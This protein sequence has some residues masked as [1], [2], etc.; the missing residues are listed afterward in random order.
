MFRAG[1]FLGRV[2]KSDTGEMGCGGVRLATRPAQPASTPERIEPMKTRHSAGRRDAPERIMREALI[3]ELDAIVEQQDGTR[4]ANKQLV[5]R[6][7]IEKACKADTAAIKEVFE[8]VDGRAGNSEAAAP[9]PPPLADLFD[10]ADEPS[11]P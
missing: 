5:A 11:A 7:L 4:I 1:M 2:R 8:R 10:D 6:A 3:R 9:R